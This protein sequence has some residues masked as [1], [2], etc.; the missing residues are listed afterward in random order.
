MD[1][2]AYLACLNADGIGVVLI[3]LDSLPLQTVEL[4]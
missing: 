2:G 1:A 3:D 4:R